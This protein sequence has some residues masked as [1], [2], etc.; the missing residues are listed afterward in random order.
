M[1]SWFSNQKCVKEIERGSHARHTTPRCMKYIYIYITWC[2]VHAF[3]QQGTRQTETVGASACNSTPN[4]IQNEGKERRKKN[5]HKKTTTQKREEKINAEKRN[6]N[7]F[8]LVSISPS[9]LPFH[10]VV[11]ECWL[12]VSVS[13]CRR[14]NYAR[15]QLLILRSS[16][17]FSLCNAKH[18]I[19]S[20]LPR[21]CVCVYCDMIWF[22]ECVR[23][24][25]PCNICC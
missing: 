11:V 5:T 10:H 18:K 20:S 23:V 19:L 14:S 16:V 4:T 25:F 8:V 12:R 1:H 6:P 22:W 13:L 7:R 17:H 24:C 2:M 3:H 21:R 15:T 9:H